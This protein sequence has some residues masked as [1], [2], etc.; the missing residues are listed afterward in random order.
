[1]SEQTLQCNW[2]IRECHNKPDTL[3][4]PSRNSSASNYMFKVNNRN[5]KARCEICSKLT[6]N[7]PECVSSVY[8]VNFEQ[9]NAG[10]EVSYYMLVL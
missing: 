10:W 4:L 3:D 9:I 2:N 7:T 6:L 1:M 8:I 5:T